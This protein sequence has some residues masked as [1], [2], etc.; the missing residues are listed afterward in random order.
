MHT[1]A[2]GLALFSVDRQA[3]PPQH[4]APSWKT[5]ME[6]DYYC[7]FNPS[8]TFLYLRQMPTNPEKNWRVSYPRRSPH[9][10]RPQMRVDV[11]QQPVVAKKDSTKPQQQTQPWFD[12]RSPLPHWQVREGPSSTLSPLPGQ[13]EGGGQTAGVGLGG[14]RRAASSPIDRGRAVRFD[15]VVKLI[16]VPSRLDLGDGLSDELWWN[17]DDYLQFRCGTLLDGL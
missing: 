5:K 15:P 6:R 2:S 16:L 14:S 4:N 3:A 17:E 9:P 8:N 10:R 12:W 7:R 1:G 13:P 11:Q